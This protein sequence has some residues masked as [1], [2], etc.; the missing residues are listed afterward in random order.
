MSC[1]SGV[2]EMLWEETNKNR[3]KGRK[4]TVEVQEVRMRK[5]MRNKK[6]IAKYYLPVTV[7]LPSRVSRY[8]FAIFIT[9]VHIC[10]YVYIHVCSRFA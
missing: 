7:V 2:N 8:N 5:R 9:V 3:E 10:L 1:K 6:I 4:E